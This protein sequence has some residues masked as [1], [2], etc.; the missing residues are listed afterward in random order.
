VVPSIARRTVGRLAR[1]AAHGRRITPGVAVRTLARQ[2]RRILTHPGHRRHALRHHRRLE[3]KFHRRY[4]RGVHPHWRYGRGRRW[5]GRYPYGHVRGRVVRGAGIPGAA[6]GVVHRP[7]VSVPAR[8]GARY[9]RVVGGQCTCPACPSCGAAAPGAA[10]APAY[11][12]CC[13]QVL[14]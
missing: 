2:T 8:A 7:G 9:G 1:Q 3:H 4:G 12:R 14:R 10:P 11:C 13:G 6:P 5:H